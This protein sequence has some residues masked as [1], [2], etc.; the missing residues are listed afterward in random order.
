[1][2]NKSVAHSQNVSSTQL[3]SK[4]KPRRSIQEVLGLNGRLT[5]LLPYVIIASLFIILPT[6][7]LVVNAAGTSPLVDKGAIASDPD[8]WRIMGKSIYL[9]IIAAVVS[10]L[11]IFPYVYIVAKSTSKMFKTVSLALIIS[12]LFVF[13]ISKVFALKG[14]LI[15]IFDGEI[16]N[17][18]VMVLGMVYLYSPFMVVPLY[19]VLQSMPKSLI[20]AS[21]DLGYSKF[22]TIFKVVI[23]YAIKGVFAGLAL[24]FMMSATNIVISNNLLVGGKSAPR[25]IGNVV[26]YSAQHLNQNDVSKITGSLIALITIAVMVVVYTLI[27]LIPT[28]IRKIKGGV[29]V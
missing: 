7:L 8:M 10:L 1:M 29:N 28:I 11:I 22:A 5:L 19:S 4:K 12:P 25:L 14:L 26:D 6:I 24:V 15:P 13:T 18:F 23:P 20:E 9:G 21:T 3:I 16:N 17:I 27:I 2:Q